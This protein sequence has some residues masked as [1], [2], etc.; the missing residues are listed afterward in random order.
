MDYA[1][2]ASGSVS[3]STT[4]ELATRGAISDCEGQGGTKCQIMLTF[5]NQCA[6]ITQRT[7]GGVFYGATAAKKPDAESRAIAKCG[8]M[9]SCTVLYSQCNYPVRVR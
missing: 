3:E 2:G 9:T 7:D 1:K 6:A 5:R 8:D 4:K